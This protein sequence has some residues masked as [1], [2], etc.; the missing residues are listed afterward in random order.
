M[1]DERAV[2]LTKVPVKRRKVTKRS[3]RRST[4]PAVLVGESGTELTNHYQDVL[5][6]LGEQRGILGDIFAGAQS[7]FSNPV[8]LKKLLGL[9]DETEWT[10][11]E[12]DVKAAAFEGLLEKAASE[13]KTDLVLAESEKLEK[14]KNL[15]SRHSQII[16]ELEGLR[17]GG[18]QKL[19]K[20]SSDYC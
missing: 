16:S 18:P 19:N 14:I 5:R 9:I 11:L 4:A 20:I 3:T 17:S 15:I 2:D 12:I 1:A 10:S 8:S 13:G 7:R 6:A